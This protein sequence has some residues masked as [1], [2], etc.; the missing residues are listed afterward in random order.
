MNHFKGRAFQVVLIAITCL[1]FYGNT[2]QN[3]YAFDDSVV[4]TENEFTLKG[5]SGI[6][7]IFGNN[8]F[9]GSYGNNPT[10]A[11]YRPLSVAT[12]AVEYQFLGLNPAFS[13]FVNVLLLILTSLVL[14]TLLSKLFGGP[15]P[16]DRLLDFPLVAAL[17]F[18]A[19][20]IHTE[21]VANIKGRDELLMLLFA[22]S[23]MMLTLQYLDTRERRSL[24]WSFLLFLL[25]LLSKENAIAFLAI[26][27][28]TMYYYKPARRPV[29]LRA[30]LPLAV[31]SAT[32][33]GVMRLVLGNSG[34]IPPQDII[35]EPFAYATL[36]E[37]FATALHTLGVYLRLLVF[38]HPLTIDYYP[39]HVKLA[40]WRSL[41]VWSSTLAH[42][43]LFL[44][45]LLNVRRRSVI[46]YGILFYLF[47]L[48]VVSNLP[49]SI[50]TFM[51]ERFM[52]VPS[53]GFV[54]IAA[55]LLTT[56][57]F[58]LLK[59]GRL[60]LLV[61]ALPCLYKTYTR[62]QVWKTDFSLFT[63]DVA[64]SQNSIKANLAA[65]VTFLMEAPKV[66]DAS[67]AQTYRAR[68]LGHSKKAVLLYEQHV[69]VDCLK[70]TSYSHALTLLGDCYA[71]V[72]ALDDALQ[73]YKKAIRSSPDQEQLGEAVEAINSKSNDVDFKFKSYTEFVDLVP[74]NFM[75]NYRLGYIYGREKHDLTNAVHYLQRAVDIRPDEAHALEALSHAYK[76]S[77]NYAK[78]AFYL[79]KSA[80]AN[81]N[82]PAHLRRLLAIY[83]LAG[84]EEKASEIMQRIGPVE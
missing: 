5:L 79:E 6:P 17:L 72:G 29:C 58:P 10:V 70:G 68:A 44:F 61:L 52:F 66:Y 76:L 23:A 12:F 3:D 32:F 51:S 63:T 13:H 39:F 28:L 84:N 57:V 35:T 1:V 56:R 71:A 41:S 7:E 49:F 30:L 2:L 43:S 67:L 73:C 16:K 19:H 83:K 47:S 42:A 27:P 9:R 65:A 75:F 77:S 36:S 18:I 8:T 80:A 74:N 50:G 24:H 60:A 45:A 40:D 54:V 4:I 33:L 15:E 11:R 26:A 55:W 59:H 21:V 48:F 37:R 69:T 34:P 62:N 53:V 31:A 78:A 38:P 14:Y 64:T 46:A 22:L 25:A 20:P 82:D 81:P